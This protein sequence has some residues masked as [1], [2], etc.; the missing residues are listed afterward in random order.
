MSPTLTRL[1]ITSTMG[2][3]GIK[4]NMDQIE[5]FGDRQKGQF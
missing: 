3:V 5:R 4:A 1:Q 2:S